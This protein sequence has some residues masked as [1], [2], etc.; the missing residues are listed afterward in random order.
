MLI[1]NGDLLVAIIGIMSPIYPIYLMNSGL[2]E[3]CKGC[4]Y[5]F[6]IIK[7][8]LQHIVNSPAINIKVVMDQNVSKPD[9]SDPFFFHLW[10]DVAFLS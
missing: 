6:K 3:F 4:F 1:G 10:C 2:K 7:V 8:V 5:F 9:H